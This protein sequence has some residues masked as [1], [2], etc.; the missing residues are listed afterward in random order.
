M[1]N[2]NQN[3]DEAN[4]KDK[5][6]SQEGKA[7]SKSKKKLIII[8]L[9]VVLLVVG[10]VAF[11]LLK[12]SSEET[13]PSETEETTTV[14]EGS[15]ATADT[16]PAPATKEEKASSETSKEKPSLLDKLTG[17]N[18][19]E[20]GETINLKPFNINLGN[21]LENRYIR[22][23][24]ALEYKG[25][26]SQRKEIERR[27]PQLRDAVISVTSKRSRESLLSTDGKDQLRKELLIIINRYMDNPIESVYIT[28]ILID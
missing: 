3:K 22:L 15:E 26:E 18:K 27:M 6:E 5:E 11:F 16:T 25:K 19:S 7:P 14:E 24:I 28:D 10:A 13:T 8:V 20:F 12:P 4:V 9:P 2:E 23:E 17:K 1:A 21:P